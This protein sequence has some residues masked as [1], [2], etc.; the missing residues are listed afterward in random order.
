MVGRKWKKKISKKTYIVKFL[1]T[2]GVKTIHNYYGMVE[3]TGS[4]FLNVKRFY[5]TSI[6]S[7]IF[8]RFRFEYFKKIKRINAI[9]FY[10]TIKLSR[11]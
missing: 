1:N 2:I 6:F 8:I 7:E 10:I 9:I 3:Q 4:S 5:H 11:T